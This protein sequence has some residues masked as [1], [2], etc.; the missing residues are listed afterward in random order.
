MQ[1]RRRE[2]IAHDLDVLI[3]LTIGERMKGNKIVKHLKKDIK[4]AKVGIKRDKK[5]IKASKKGC[6]KAS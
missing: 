5:L 4:E 2:G 1:R 6:K 3:E